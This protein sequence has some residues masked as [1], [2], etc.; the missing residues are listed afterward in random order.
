M[1]S[2]ALMAAAAVPGGMAAE[3]IPERALWRMK[4]TTSVLDAM[5]PPTVAR[6][7]EKVPITRSTSSSM[8][9]CSPVPRPDSPMTPTP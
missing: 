6:D 9:K 2:M 7:F 5:K 3:K 1:I 4:S 8:P